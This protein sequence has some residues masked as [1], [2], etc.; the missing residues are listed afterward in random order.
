M[1]KFTIRLKQHTPLIHFQHDQE[2][3]TLRASEV[4]PKLDQFLKETFNNE[5]NKDLIEQLSIS[6][7]HKRSPY[8]VF[9]QLEDADS[10]T[11]YVI[12]SYI[13]KN[14]IQNYKENEYKVITPSPYFADDSE[15]KKGNVD[16]IKLGV[17]TGKQILLRFTYFNT[18]W[19]ELLKKAVPL[20]FAKY[21]FGSRQSKGFGCFYPSV[22][23]EKQFESCLIT[24]YDVV[25]KYQSRNDY[26][27]SLF[28]EI[29]NIYKKL[30]SGDR[31]RESE[32]RKYFNALRPAV[33][34]E[35]PAIQ[36]H[37]SEISR[38]NLRI[39]AI[40]DEIKFIRALLGLPELYEYPMH[41]DIKVKVKHQSATKEDKIER[42]ASPILFKVFNRNIYLVL[43]QTDSIEGKEFSFEFVQKG[44][45]YGEREKLTVPVGFDL[46]EFIEKAMIS[47]TQWKK[48]IRNG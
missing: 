39:N 10:V 20:F 16:K 11:E 33:D 31:N 15:I 46:K 13:A 28:G 34:W 30:K 14:K 36:K 48:I 12:G 47:N 42:F 25:Y 23:D 43:N 8:K 45:S 21:N 2:G 32:L 22:L 1:N 18:K 9:I 6:G 27:N 4:K 38:R 24:Q 40:S 3:A 37:V 44:R 35:K 19:E 26:L 17:M 29:N 41:G 7:D 5:E